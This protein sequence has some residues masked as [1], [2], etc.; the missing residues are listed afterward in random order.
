MTLNILQPPGTGKT[1]TIVETVSLLKVCALLSVIGLVLITFMQKHFG[2][3]HPLLVCTYTNV[4]V[5]N[6][7][8]GFSAAGVNAVRVGFEGKAKS[9]FEEST[10]EYQFDTHPLQSDYKKVDDDLADIQLRIRELIDSIKKYMAL[11]NMTP[12]MQ[13]R[14]SGYSYLTFAGCILN[15][16]TR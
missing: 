5:D 1:K 3:V 11:N 6:L 8:E 4:A 2:V 12:N 9:G 14:I 16:S 10:I 13:S 15:M 7:V